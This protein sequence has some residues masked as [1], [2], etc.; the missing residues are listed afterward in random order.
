MKYFASIFITKAKQLCHCYNKVYTVLL[1]GGEAA[2]WPVW[3]VAWLWVWPIFSDPFG[4][5]NK[6]FQGPRR[7]IVKFSWVFFTFTVQKPCQAFT[8][9]I[10]L[11]LEIPT[12]SKQSLTECGWVSLECLGIWAR[13]TDTIERDV[14][15]IT[16]VLSLRLLFHHLV[17]LAA[18]YL[19]NSCLNVVSLSIFHIYL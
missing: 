4:S 17:L 1:R 11:P 14:K 13:Q 9:L 2:H 16:V 10:E 8:R 19:L 3:C 15:L 5:H 7:R 6:Y 18:F 12:A